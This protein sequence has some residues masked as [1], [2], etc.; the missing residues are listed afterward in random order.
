MNSGQ[1][2]RAPPPLPEAA[3][4]AWLEAMGIPCWVPRQTPPVPSLADR[5]EAADRDARPAHGTAGAA[6]GTDAVEQPVDE[7]GDGA[8]AAVAR[9]DWEALHTTVLGC[10]LCGLCAGRTQAVF[11]V[12]SREAD[13]LVIGEAPGQ[14]EDRE[15]E[16]FVGPAGQLLDRMLSAIG[17]DRQSV[18]ITNVLKCR[19]PRNR[20]PQAEEAQACAPYLRRQIELLEPRVILAVGR[21]SCQQLL[22]TDAS[23]GR[24]RGRWHRYGPRDTP[25]RV[26]YHPAYL[27][28]RPPEKAKAW[29]DLCAVRAALDPA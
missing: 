29:A 22:E 26:T 13:L 3:R 6:S 4:R 14:E 1:G 2:G 7:V 27:L 10:R 25:L 18:Y 15:G 24:L 12:G 16:P 21:I 11:G 8:R 9:M 17:L 19:P 28:R 23:I 5:V 20:D